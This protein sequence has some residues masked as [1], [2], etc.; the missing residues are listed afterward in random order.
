MLEKHFGKYGECDVRCGWGVKTRSKRVLVEP[1]NGGAACGKKEEK[2]PCYGLNCKVPRAPGGFEELRG[3]CL[4][5]LYRNC[6]AKNC[7]RSELIS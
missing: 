1:K 4:L 2:I 6:C 3:K 7:G 5:Y